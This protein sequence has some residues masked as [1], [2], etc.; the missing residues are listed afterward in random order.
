MNESNHISID[1]DRRGGIPTIKGT[2]YTL[3]GLLAALSRDD[4]A[5]RRYAGDGD[6]LGFEDVRQTLRAAANYFDR[7]FDPATGLPLEE[8]GRR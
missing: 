2:R 6:A 5:I 3:A 8:A 1:P 4:E 7:P